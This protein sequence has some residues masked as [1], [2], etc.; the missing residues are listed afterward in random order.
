ML[1]HV[2]GQ[3]FENQNK[4][5][6]GPS[7]FCCLLHF[8][9]MFFKFSKNWLIIFL[10]FEL[11]LRLCLKL[12]WN[13]HLFWKFFHTFLNFSGFFPQIFEKSAA[14]WEFLLNVSKFFL[15]IFNFLLSC[16]FLKIFLQFFR[17]CANFKIFPRARKFSKISPK[18]PKVFRHFFLKFFEI[19]RNFS[20]FLRNFAE[21]PTKV[22]KFLKMKPSFTAN[23]YLTAGL[24]C[25]L[26]TDQI[27]MW[28]KESTG[29]ECQF[30]VTRKDCA[31]CVKPGGCQCGSVSPN[32]CAQC[33]LQQFCNN[34][35][36]WLSFFELLSNLKLDK[37]PQHIR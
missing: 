34:S 18:I 30:D 8:L 16:I 7:N 26:F 14:T 24:F 37:Y 25:P 11:F 17:I 10:R 35:K 5:M 20:Q 36:F 12:L 2:G 31:C 22:L 33:G 9:K 4:G 32:K 15:K 19:S 28:T 6:C 21:F 3:T 27:D 23:F 29:C 13:L 1:C